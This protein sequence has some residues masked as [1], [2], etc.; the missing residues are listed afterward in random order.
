MARTPSILGDI[1]M[2][3]LERLGKQGPTKH[4]D[5]TT[6]RGPAAASINQALGRLDPK[7][8]ISFEDYGKVAELPT[9]V[10]TCPQTLKDKCRDK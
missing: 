1:Q 5:G 9:D 7:H 3:H 6:I 10:Y 8:K 4:A 2:N